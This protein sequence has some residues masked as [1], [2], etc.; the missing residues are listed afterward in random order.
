M[1]LKCNL[2]LTYIFFHYFLKAIS[3]PGWVELNTY[4]PGLAINFFLIISVKIRVRSF[5]IG[6]GEGYKVLDDFFEKKILLT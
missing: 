2:T 1:K 6:S 3:R 4:I 5:E